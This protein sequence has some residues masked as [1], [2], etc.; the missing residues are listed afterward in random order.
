[1]RKFTKIT[2]DKHWTENDS[3]KYEAMDKFFNWCIKNEHSKRKISHEDLEL[4]GDYL[5]Y[6][7]DNQKGIFE[8]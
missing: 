2:E 5:I 8:K 3:R 4:F 1:M 6:L 7:E